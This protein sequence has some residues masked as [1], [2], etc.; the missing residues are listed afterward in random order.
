MT[1]LQWDSDL[2]VIKFT[3]LHTVV[4]EDL[5][6]RNQ[7]CEEVGEDCSKWREKQVQRP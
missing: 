6:T 5:I 3:Y 7:P 2:E 1:M 4:K